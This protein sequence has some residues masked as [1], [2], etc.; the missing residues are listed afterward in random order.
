[1]GA[2]S[3]H[4]PDR[5]YLLEQAAETYRQAFRPSADLAEPYLVVGANVVAADTTER[6]Q[7]AL[8]SIR[9]TMASGMARPR[10][11]VQTDID[12]DAADELL[13]G[14]IG[15]QVD[16]LLHY[17]AVGDPNDVAR[18]LDDLAQAVEADEII[19]A[20]QMPDLED[21][22]RSVALTVGSAAFPPHTDIPPTAQEGP[23][24]HYPAMAVTPLPDTGRRPPGLTSPP[25]GPTQYQS[26]ATHQPTEESR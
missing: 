17:T 1:M 19:T 24:N 8:L 20:H 23:A 21:R 7:Q 13:S 26:T 6:A 18:Y 10:L 4:L 22:L 11:P 12:E 2:A 15:E 25:S 16:K 5:L 3:P 14:P 9:R